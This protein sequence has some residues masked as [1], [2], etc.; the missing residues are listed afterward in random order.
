MPPDWF[1]TVICYESNIYNGFN[2]L[3]RHVEVSYKDVSNPKTNIL[4]F[5]IYLPVMSSQLA[6]NSGLSHF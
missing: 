2:I 6:C 4:S 5:F 3:Y 1:V